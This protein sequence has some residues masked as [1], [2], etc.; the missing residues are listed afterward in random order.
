M[1]NS[2]GRIWWLL[3]LDNTQLQRDA[4]V[5]KEQFRRLG[6][7]ATEE[8]NR[9][10]TALRNAAAGL[11]AFLSIQQLAQFSRSIAEVRGEFQQ[12]EVAFK[13]MLGNKGQADKLMAQLVKTAATTP[14]DLKSVAGGAKQLLAYGTSAEEVN[15]ILIRLGD[16]AAGL[17]IPLGDL[18]YL[19]GTTMTQGRMFTMDLRQFMGR[20]IPMAEELAKIFGVAKDQVADLVSEGKVGASEMKKAIEN[21]TSA[22]GK[23]NNLMAEQSKTITGQISNLQDAIDTMMNEIGRSNEGLINDVISGASYMVEHY[24]EIGKILGVL[25]S[26]YGAYKAAVITAHAIQGASVM[27][28][29]IKAWFQLASGIRSAKDAQIAFNLA[30]KANPLGLLLALITAVGTAIWA[31]GKKTDDATDSISGLA[32][33]NKEATEEMDRQSAKIKALEDVINNSNIAN[34]HRRKAI[35][36][37][38]SIIPSYNAQLDEEGRLI[39]NNTEAIK[40][41]LTQLERQIRMK[42]AQ[43]ELEEA[44]KSE[45]DLQR[46]LSKNKSVYDDKST[47]SAYYN[48][49]LIDVAGWFGK[50]DLQEAE[51]ALNNT[52]TKLQEVRNTISELKREIELSSQ[53][54]VATVS[55]GGPTEEEIA[56]AEKRAKERA[57]LEADAKRNLEELT[58]VERELVYRLNQS[59]IDLMS[60][61]FEKEM[62]QLEFDHQRRKD[63]ITEFGKELLDAQNRI[64]KD[65]WLKSGKKEESFTPS[66]QLDVTSKGKIDDL[67][68]AEDRLFANSKVELYKSLLEKYQDFTAKRKEIEEGFNA[69]VKV[70]NSLRTEENAREIESAIAEAG[71][72]KERQ[73]EALKRALLDDYGLGGLL[74]GDMSDF[75]TKEVK[76]SIPLFHSL[77]EATTSQLLKAKEAIK[78]I[79]L[80]DKLVEELEEAGYNTEELVKLLQEA[81]KEATEQIDETFFSKLEGVVGKLSHALGSLGNSLSELGG[82]A[83]EI[84]G[85]MSGLSSGMEN[86]MTVFKSGATST[87]KISAGIGAALTLI[88]MVTNQIQANRI[89]QQKWRDAI[90]ESV[91]QASLL[92]IES[93][94]YKQSNLFGVENPYSRAIAGAKQYAQSMFELN[95]A[96]AKLN[97]G[98]IQT[99]TKKVV[100]GI[101]VATGAAAGAVLGTVVPGIGNAVGAVVGAVVGGLIGLFTRKT[102]P[103][104]ESLKKKYG[105]IYNSET[106]ELNPD[107]LR[108]YA[109]LDEATKKLVDNWKEIKDKALQAQEEMRQNFKDLAGDLGKQLSDSLV[110]AFRNGDIYSA[111][112]D[113]D[114]YLSSTIE[115]IISQLIFAQ[116]FQERL[117]ELEKL[118]N[119]SF[120][121]GG[122]MDIT[123]DLVWFGQ[124]YSKGIEEYLKAMEQARQSMREQGYELWKPDTTRTASQKGIASMNQQSADELNGRFAVMQGHTYSINESVKILSNNSVLILKHLSNIDNNTSRLEN[125]EKDISSV[126]SG[127]DT[128][129]LKGLTI[130]K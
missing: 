32:K 20:G 93:L 109:K 75:F 58:K 85:I 83:G 79:E 105:E 70:L 35:N 2:D 3:G 112:D 100:S 74:S 29:N 13:V 71:K 118:F 99:G 65:L 87:D 6:N 50:T 26:T 81:K 90:A 101:N 62:A 95:S 86:L 60:D 12:L 94:A 16:I 128:I 30:T 107:I 61:G 76:K 123:D 122:D 121:E 27:A 64:E 125:I 104:F 49:P 51:S 67:N 108:D 129:N 53:P 84:G 37:L 57:K 25:I 113:F 106:F 7:T 78:G 103:V 5:T 56:E 68:N 47:N 39:N 110:S 21:M 23:F 120:G 54:V 34:E 115:N 73:L 48:R 63:A 119:S 22:G 82:T 114:N 24:E 46:E 111:I 91:H 72:N 98:Q 36:D 117:G 18:V 116:I 38:K 89:E 55:G 11:A 92:R 42:A 31:F 17:S 9:I 1:N 44:Y 88:T 127:I 52:K 45:R 40:L 96:V 97:E 4:N 124:E 102:V 69:D 80:P 66:T 8:G 43:D 41:Y 15:E 28:G 33:A 77:A 10:N 19:Y 126:R 59:K 130:R 14:F